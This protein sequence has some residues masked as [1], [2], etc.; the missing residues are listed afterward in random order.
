[1][2]SNTVERIKTLIHKR[3]KIK[4]VVF[5]STSVAVLVLGILLSILFLNRFFFFLS[6]VP[7]FL[8]IFFIFKREDINNVLKKIEKIDPIKYEK[9]KNLFYFTTEVPSKI[10]SSLLIEKYIKITDEEFKKENFSYILKEP[11][12]FTAFL[13]SIGL[14]LFSVFFFSKEENRI[15]F[16][17]LFLNTPAPLKIT[18]SSNKK[19]VEKDEMVDIY[20]NVEGKIIPKTAELVIKGSKEEKKKVKLKEKIEVKIN[21]DCGLYLTALGVKSNEIRIK[22][23][24]PLKIENIR[25]SFVFPSYT[26]VK[27]YTTTSKEFSV[28]KG[29]L[30]KLDGSLSVSFDSAFIFT[31][32]HRKV[33][34]KNG[35]KNF[36]GEFTVYEEGEGEIKFFSVDTVSYGFKVNIIPDEFPAVE[37]ITPGRDIDMPEDMQINVVAE[38]YDDYGVKNVYL[39]LFKKTDTLKKFK[40]WVG[41]KQDSVYFLVDLKELELMPGDELYYYMIVEDNDVVSGPKFSRS[42]IFKIRFPTMEEIYNEAVEYSVETTQE[43]E[44]IQETQKEISFALDRIMEKL[45]SEGRLSYEEKRNLEKVLDDQKNVVKNLEELKNRTEELIKRMEEQRMFD[46]ETIKIL[47]DLKNILEEVLPP[48]TKKMLM[49]VFSKKELTEKDIEKLQRMKEE[50]KRNL[51]MTLELMKRYL[52]EKRLQEI[53]KKFNYLKK[54]QE[55]AIKEKDIKRKIEEQEGIEEGVKKIREEIRKL[56]EEI[57]EKD[58]RRL[59]KNLAQQVSEKG[60]KMGNRISNSLKKGEIPKELMQQLKRWF[61]KWADETEQIA[62][63]LRMKRQREVTSELMKLIREVIVSSEITE[64]AIRDFERGDQMDAMEKIESVKD[65]I[66]RYMEQ[67]VSLG[68][69]NL[70]ISRSAI[71]AFSHTEKSMQKAIEEF[72]KGNKYTARRLIQ[73][74]K[75]NIDIA[76]ISLLKSFQRICS[77]C[78]ESSTGVEELLRA[79]SSIAQQQLSLNQ[80]ISLLPLPVSVQALSPKEQAMLAQILAQQREIRKK[81]EKIKEEMGDMVGLTGRLDGIIEEMKQ[82]EE[83]LKKQIIPRDIV[84]RQE[85]IFRR[86]LDAQKSLY[87]SK[88]AS[89]SRKREIGE[90]YTQLESPVLDKTKGERKLF[91]KKELIKAMQEDYSVE[92]KILLKEYYEALIRGEK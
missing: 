22:I 86:L 23:A 81:L 14:F 69:K 58:V 33:K 62:K 92:I 53:S 20:V 54:M 11:L 59:L 17:Y 74:A 77:S 71:R 21:E 35:Y 57:E 15:A 82:T 31:P 34:L 67:L 38:V 65:G 3:Y 32:S 41:E 7:F 55:K 5:T 42:Q 9:I 88:E 52:Q 28:L 13:I 60:I 30:V 61:E 56:A 44:T 4:K 40:K 63:M 27:S 84:K 47:K 75:R 46:Y 66:P 90:D 79:L 1:M 49:D 29:T 89:K 10:Y 50:I 80:Q 45:K 64:E 12:F 43:L 78:T 70:R 39:V 37:I 68:G 83:E 72:V 73:E 85:R 51:K 26:G 25:F 91:L 36:S 19:V 16:N 6:L 24:H 87:K 76:S 8:S 18:L 2:Y 48:E